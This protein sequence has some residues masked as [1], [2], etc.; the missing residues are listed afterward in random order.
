MDN[1]G[2]VDQEKEEKKK[3]DEN[4]DRELKQTFPA[5]DPPSHSRPGDDDKENKRK[6]N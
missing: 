3:M 1:I 4:L 5:S 6:A 2:K